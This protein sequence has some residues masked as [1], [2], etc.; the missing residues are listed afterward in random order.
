M[1]QEWKAFN[2]F[3]IFLMGI[4]Y[5]SNILKVKTYYKF[6]PRYLNLLKVPPGNF[7]CRIMHHYMIWWYIKIMLRLV[8]LFEILGVFSII[9]VYNN[10]FSCK[11]LCINTGKFSSY[12]GLGHK[13]VNFLFLKCN[14]CE[15]YYFWLIK[16]ELV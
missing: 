12:K 15:Y 14:V 1:I 11:Y 5:F 8:C 4:G 2:W 16:T 10:G 7:R 9:I 3:P 13:C 6:V